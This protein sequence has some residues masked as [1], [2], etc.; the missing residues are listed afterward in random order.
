MQLNLE[1]RRMETNYR[2]KLPNDCVNECPIS[3]KFVPITIGG[4]T[5]PVGLIQ[6][7]WTDFDI[8][9][10]KNWLHIY[11]VKI[12]C[13]DL[14][15]IL[16]DEKGGEVLFYGQRQKNPIFWFLLWK[17]VSYYVKGV[18]DICIMLLTPKQKKRKQEISMQFVNL[19]M[20]FL[21]SF[22]D[23]SI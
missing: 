15:V 10:E 20:L 8:I 18:L 1:D 17:Q 23:Y 6:F 7:D 3:Y 21:R 22:Q 19:K 11:G 16:N 9:L 13:E 2:I 14:K 5:F 12:D 4:T